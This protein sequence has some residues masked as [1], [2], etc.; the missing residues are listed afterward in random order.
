MCCRGGDEEEGGLCDPGL[1]CYPG[2]P[3]HHC[4]CSRPRQPLP[5]LQQEVKLILREL[6]LLT[7]RLRERDEDGIVVSDWKFAAMLI[8][9]W[10]A[11]HSSIVYPAQVLPVRPE[12]LH[13][14]HH[15][16][17]L[18]IRPAPHSKVSARPSLISCHGP[19][20][21]TITSLPKSQDFFL[22]FLALQ[23]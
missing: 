1:S 11:L 17:P 12:S 8:D 7:R 14:P 13:H 19:R 2:P 20:Q 6:R 3:H 22:L 21:Q 4:C 15:R 10:T 23:K 5:A 9:R 18:H 16:H